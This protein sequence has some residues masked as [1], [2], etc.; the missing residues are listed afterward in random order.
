MKRMISDVEG[1]KAIGALVQKGTKRVSGKAAPKKSAGKATKPAKKAEAKPKADKPKSDSNVVK[2]SKK[3]KKELPGGAI[4]R[5]TVLP[6]KKG[7]WKQLTLP[8]IKAERVKPDKPAVDLPFDKPKKPNYKQPMLPGM[9]QP[10]R[11]PQ[12]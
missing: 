3:H 1:A 12:G 4:A 8:G 2:E 5:G 6:E 7:K 10:K 11:Y 9:R